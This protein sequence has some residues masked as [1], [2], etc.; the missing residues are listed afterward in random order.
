MQHQPLLQPHKTVLKL[1]SVQKSFGSF[2]AVENVDLDVGE[3]QL[4][5]LLGPS[6]CGKTT[7]LRMI[8]G[9]EFP[10][11][12]QIII[13]GK[14]VTATPPNK[15]EIGIVFQSYSLFPHMRVADNVAY[16]LKRRG[17][18]KEERYERVKTALELVDLAAF[19]DRLPSE[20]SG[21]QQQR[22]ALARAIVIRP[23][24]L[25][26]DEPLS[27]LDAK[28]RQRMRSEIRHLQKQIGMTTIL[29]THD[30]E[31]ALSMSD[32]IVVMN[33][34]RIEQEGS[35]VNIYK[36]PKTSFVASFIG[37]TNLFEG[38]IV[39]PK[40]DD[41][42]RF[43]ADCGFETSIAPTQERRSGRKTLLSLRPETLLISSKT[44]PSTLSNTVDGTILGVSYLGARTVFEVKTQTRQML[45]SVQNDDGSRNVASDTFVEGQ[46]I[47]LSWAPEACQLVEAR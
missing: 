3:N 19:K 1:A 9:F 26:L 25:L 18:P 29:V 34:G 47:N 15:R 20:L 39:E 27:A 10:T 16:G 14:D 45:V 7:T 22:V 5:T 42:P 32:H 2:V 11:A 4:V 31:E 38:E 30:Q 21:G 24:I 13:D 46:S 37:E 17:V 23:K 28:L 41:L 8:A 6:G 36:E 44:S 12:G 35:P 33:K 43:R 40:G